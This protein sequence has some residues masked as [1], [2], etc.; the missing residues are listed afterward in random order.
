MQI[1][2]NSNNHCSGREKAKNSGRTPNP[3][4][5]S[6]PENQ[7][8]WCCRL[9]INENTSNNNEIIQ[10]NSIVMPNIRTPIG[11]ES[12]NENKALPAAAGYHDQ[13]IA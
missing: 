13:G 8:S 12:K 3:R 10:I 11:V 9:E 6:A 7:R 1:V 2:K 5:A 4:T